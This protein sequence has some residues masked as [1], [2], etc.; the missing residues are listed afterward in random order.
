MCVFLL[1]TFNLTMIVLLLIGN[2]VMDKHGISL[3][4]HGY[5][6]GYDPKVNPGI[7]VEF[8]GSAFRFGHSILPDT[9][10]RYNKF[11]EKLGECS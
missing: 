1:E 10:E 4:K 2:K 8:Q 3:L 9:T 6:N 11:H 5:Y 7:R